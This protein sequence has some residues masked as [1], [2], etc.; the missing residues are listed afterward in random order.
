MEARLL[1]FV[2]VILPIRNESLFIERSLGAV[3]AQDYPWD[4]MEVLIAD[5]MSEDGTRDIIAQLSAASPA[6]PLKIIDNL[7]GIVSTG[8]NAALIHARGDVVVR[9]DGHS[10]IPADYVSSCV[11][12]LQ[13]SGAD[14]VGG[15]ML[16]VGNG[17]FA[18]AVSVATRSRFGIGTAR[19]HY[20]DRQQWSDTGYMGAWPRAVF[21]WIGR[22]D[23]QLVR[24]QDDELTYRLLG[25]GGRVLLSPRIRS[26]YFNRSTVRSLW[27]Q[28][29]QYGYW[30]VRVMQK[31]PRQM[32]PRQFAPPLFVG[33]LLVLAAGFSL[34]VVGLAPLAAV[35]GT[36]VATSIGASVVAASHGNLASM[37]LLPL[38]FAILHMSYGLGFLHGLVK[39][40]RSWTSAAQTVPP[41]PSESP[42]NRS[43]R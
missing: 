41:L 40:R 35:A 29:Y 12:V 2:S 38:A 19:F 36:Y 23:E 15:R 39:F 28:Y 27:R 22:F 8:L 32:R 17:T 30:K 42:G 4:R 7:Q 33:T 34:G 37:P 1:P 16:A 11:T 6:I 14:C 3:L 20:S 18:R 24:N 26:K 21:D 5:G 10:I 9:V 31:H 43:A 13:E 25:Q